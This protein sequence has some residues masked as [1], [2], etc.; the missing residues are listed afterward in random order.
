ME[1]GHARQSQLVDVCVVAL[2]RRADLQTP[3]VRD[4]MGHISSN[5]GQWA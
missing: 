4:I 3:S 1:A 2:A 5:L